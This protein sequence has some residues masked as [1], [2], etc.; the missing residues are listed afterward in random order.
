MKR[1]G[2]NLS[3][4]RQLL[5][6]V[7]LITVLVVLAGIV[8]I[9]V[10]I[11]L[12]ALPAAPAEPVLTVPTKIPPTLQVEEEEYSYQTTTR[13]SN[14]EAV[15]AIVNSV[16]SFPV[17]LEEEQAN[18]GFVSQPV[19]NGPWAN[20]GNVSLSRLA[21]V[22]EGSISASVFAQA[23]FDSV[24]AQRLAENSTAYLKAQ[25]RTGIWWIVYASLHVM[26]HSALTSNPSNGEGPLGITSQYQVGFNF[27]PGQLSP[28]GLANALSSAS[29]TI[30]LHA[31]RAQSVTNIPMD[32]NT[33]SNWEAIQSE[34]AFTWNGRSGA[35]VSPCDG[36]TYYGNAMSS[37]YVATNW[38]GNGAM[39]VRKGSGGL[40]VCSGWVEMSRDGYMAN[41]AKLLRVA[42]ALT[43]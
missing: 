16:R 18:Q 30:I 28:D 14:A 37:G 2:G 32:L 7:G 42:Q 3:I 11:P 21:Q 4:W 25:N 5:V 20:S 13:K 23:G 34:F 39:F 35:V 22:L 38:N 6:L 8:R 29:Q 43:Q 1:D 10:K 9:F 26:E 12:P 15:I 40:E 31:E 41:F 33:T 19:Y 24:L 27:T 17:A 36:R